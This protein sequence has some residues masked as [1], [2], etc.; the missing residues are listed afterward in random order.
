MKKLLS[1]VAALSI[2]SVSPLLAQTEDSEVGEKYHSATKDLVCSHVEFAKAAIERKCK[3][4][5]K[6]IRKLESQLCYLERC[7]GNADVDIERI[8]DRTELRNQI[9]MYEER[10]YNLRLLK[11][12]AEIIDFKSFC[13]SP[14]P[15]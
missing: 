8:N 11:S 6:R 2:L 12:S 1:L 3:K 5:K 7:G 4:Y 15:S 14:M 13:E 9:Q 10:I